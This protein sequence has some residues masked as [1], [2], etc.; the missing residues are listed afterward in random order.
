MKDTN[1]R[2]VIFP[3]PGR[4]VKWSSESDF[5]LNDVPTY[6]VADLECVLTKLDEK[7]KEHTLGTSTNASPVPLWLL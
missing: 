1:T 4:E 2:P 7:K 5:K 3:S 6:L